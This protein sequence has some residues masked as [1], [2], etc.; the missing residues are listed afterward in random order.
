MTTPESTPTLDKVMSQ[1]LNEFQDQQNLNKMNS[2][3]S[4]LS[5]VHN[6]IVAARKFSKEIEGRDLTDEQITQLKTE[7]EYFSTN[8]LLGDVKQGIAD[9]IESGKVSDAERAL[10]TLN[11]YCKLAIVVELILVEVS[12]YIREEGPEHNKMPTIYHSYLKSTRDSDKKYLEFLH[13]PEMKEAL[14]AAIYQHGPQSYPELRDYIKA[15]NVAPIPKTGLEEGKT[16]Y[17]TPKKWP[18]WY[19]YLSSEHKSLIYGSTKLNEQSKFVLRRALLGEEGREWRIENKYYPKYFI[20]ARKFGSC[21][22]E[23]KNP[24]EVSYVEGL[25]MEYFYDTEATCHNQCG[26]NRECMG[27]YSNCYTYFVA[28]NTK[29]QVS[30]NYKWRFTKLKPKGGSTYYFISATQENF[31]PG[32]TLFMKDSNNA[33]AYLKYGNPK[34]EGMFK[35]TK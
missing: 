14:V 34:E 9:E 17:L 24:D 11:V 25:T 22:S 6:G 10:K 33:N 26:S 19:F 29:N 7:I 8:A 1:V 31:G 18:Q 3:V 28:G 20:S 13:L 27:C 30:I 2:F 15:I 16:I 12:N 35:L 23:K 21:L 5:Q 4:T 32:Y